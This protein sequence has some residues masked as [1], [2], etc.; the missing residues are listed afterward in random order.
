MRFKDI[1][2]LLMLGLILAPAAGDGVKQVKDFLSKDE[3]VAFARSSND[4]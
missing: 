2:S 3:I 4:S 1:L